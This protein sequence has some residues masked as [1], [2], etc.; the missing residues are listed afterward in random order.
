VPNR[1]EQEAL[2]LLQEECA[3]VIQAVSKIRR[4]GPDFRARGGKA[5][6]TS[7]EE[8]Q[9]EVYDVVLMLGYLS[10]A[11][12]LDISEEAVVRYAQTEKLE[13]L[14][15]WTNLFKDL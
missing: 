1:Q 11:G 10:D 12:F 15:T 7:R 9:R 6:Y 14:R 5:D 2:D 3:E 4:F 8:L 13:K